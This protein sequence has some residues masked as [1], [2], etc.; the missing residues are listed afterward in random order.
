M[1]YLALILLLVPFNTFSQETFHVNSTQCLDTKNTFEI[2]EIGEYIKSENGSISYVQGDL[3][4]TFYVYRQKSDGEPLSG[5]LYDKYPNG[6]LKYE[7]EYKKGKV[8]NKWFV[9][10]TQDKN[11]PN[12]AIKHRDN[13][14]GAVT[15]ISSY[16]ESHSETLERFRNNK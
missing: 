5:I 9:Y 10:Y 15:K 12:Y 11:Q 13:I 6:D 14:F 2:T 1:K 7:I 4:Q 8:L 16:H 3:I